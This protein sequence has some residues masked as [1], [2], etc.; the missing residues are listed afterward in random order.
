MM[1]QLGE[2]KRLS[3]RQVWKNEASEFTPWL[4]ENISSLA[5]SLG[6]ELD[7]IER[8]A[9]IGDFAADLVAKDI[10]SDR[11]V[12]I[13]NQLATTDHSHL[14]QILTYAANRKAGVI[15]WIAPKFR[16]EHR[17]SLEW[18]N[19]VTDENIDFFGLQLELL[20]IDDSAPAPNF[21]IVAKPSA[22]QKETRK[23]EQITERQQAYHDFFAA[24][25]QELKAKSPSITHADSV[26]YGSSIGIYAG[27]TGFSYWLSFTQDKRFRV[28]LYI[29]VGDK[30]LNKKAFDRLRQDEGQI[31]RE[32]GQTVEW[33][34]LDTKR[35]CRIAVYR[36]DSRITNPAESLEEIRKWA[37]QS[38]ITLRKTMA[39][40]INNI[41]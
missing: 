25:L 20:Q 37:V 9:P 19:D 23:R 29:D 16:D 2:L 6:L 11:Y 30:G 36:P 14:G 31:N 38:V 34:R 17:Q 7:L 8:E 26:G 10:N 21:T 35:A 27:K 12:V 40:R 18:L 24:L 33:E 5:A 13:E 28:E 1:K 41:K 32:M 22:W 3:P 15:V 4:R 39:P